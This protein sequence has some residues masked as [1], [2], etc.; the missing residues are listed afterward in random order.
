[1][2]I[3]KPLRMLLCLIILA[4]PVFFLSCSD[5]GEEEP[6]IPPPNLEGMYIHGTN[7]IAVLA[8]DEGAKM[9]LALLD[10]N[11][12]AKVESMD[13]IYGK[14]LYI[15]AG[16]KIQFTEVV[17]VNG[18]KVAAVYGAAG[19]GSVDSASVVG[20]VA[21]KDVVIHGTLVE[22]GQEVNVAE[23]GLYYAYVDTN[24]YSFVLMKVK[25]QIIGDATV[26]MW[27]S[28]TSLPQIYVSK[29]SSVFQ[30][31]NVPLKGSSGYRYRFNDGWHVHQDPNIVTLSSLGVPSYGE[32]WDTGV[33]N[34]GFHLDNIPHKQ[35]GLYTVRLKYTA[36]TGEWK[37][38]KIRTGDYVVPVDYSAYNMQIIGD[39]T[40]N[41]SWNGDGSGGYGGHTPS[42]DGNVYTWTW[43]DAPLLVDK[44][45][46]FLQDATWGKF[47]LDYS[48]ATVNGT[49]ISNSKIIDATTAPVN[50]PYHNFHVM[51]AGS[52]DVTLVIDAA[53]GTKTITINL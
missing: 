26:N 31:T 33:N 51:E 36:A 47:Q 43:N 11:Q 23:E 45:F 50:G 52:Y 35:D 49:A 22:N 53:T 5:D 25:G 32:A 21:I 14:F 13:G 9:N 7:N 16:G 39:A 34:I 18:T 1:M 37:E 40:A 19:G 42:K 6:V 12:G 41:G 15:G 27:A 30:A 44:E 8:T 29:D 48:Q 3:M 20:N 46:I 24:D 28:G 10:P 4:L 17:D 2:F 38:T